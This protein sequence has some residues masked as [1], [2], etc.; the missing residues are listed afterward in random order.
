MSA[1]PEAE[2]AHVWELHRGVRSEWISCGVCHLVW[3]F[4]SMLSEC[5]AARE[6]IAALLKRYPY[7]NSLE[8]RLAYGA[9]LNAGGPK[10]GKT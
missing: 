8:T 4:D 9:Y 5:L 3:A 1:P 7:N 10:L 2:C 6:L